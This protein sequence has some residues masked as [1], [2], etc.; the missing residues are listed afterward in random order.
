V[1]AIADQ[2]GEEEEEAAAAAPAGGNLAALAVARI[3]RCPIMT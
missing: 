3:A 1:G 2:E